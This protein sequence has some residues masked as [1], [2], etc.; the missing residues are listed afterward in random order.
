M[1]DAGQKFT[2]LTVIGPATPNRWG[3][4]RTECVCDCG[5]TVIVCDADLVRREK[6]TKSCGDPDA[7]GCFGIE[8]CMGRVR[9]YEFDSVIGVGGVSAQPRSQN[10]AGKINWVGLGARKKSVRNR[11]APVVTFRHFV[12]Y[13]EKGENIRDRAPRLARHLLSK[14]ARVLVN[15]TTQ[16]QHEINQILRLAK[17]APPSSLPSRLPDI[18]CVKKCGCDTR[19]T[20]PKRSPRTNCGTEKVRKSPPKSPN[21]RNSTE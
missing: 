13:E 3:R 20:P 5:K 21:N 2:R 4:P 19:Q 10:I 15:F 17:N 18:R 1:I 16:E 12:L 7:K 8:D 11:K 9:G 6:S 14:N